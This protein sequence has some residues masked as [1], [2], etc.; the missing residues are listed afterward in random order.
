MV[1]ISRIRTKRFFGASIRWK[2]LLAFFVIVA[3]S[4]GV[5]AT[6]L[7]GLVRDYLFEQRTREDSVL[8]EKAAA[9]AAPFFAAASPEDVN[10]V[11]EEN[12]QA[13]DGRLMLVD[14]DG[15][16]QYDTLREMSGHRLQLDEVL[17]VL[18]GTAEQAYGI[19][20]PS[21]RSKKYRAPD[22]LANAADELK[23]ITNYEYQKIDGSRRI[24]EHLRLD[25]SNRSASFNMLVS[26]IRRILDNWN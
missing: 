23:R 11:L 26:G 15:K 21:Q 7:T 18:T 14:R 3:L 25:G 10:R 19:H 9:A 17:R 6:N 16:V 8:P 4:F 5:A 20:L 2:I 12:A 24:A 22:A 13:M 1:T